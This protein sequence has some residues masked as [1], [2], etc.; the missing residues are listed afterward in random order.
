MIQK[1]IMLRINEVATAHK[2]LVIVFLQSVQLIFKSC[3][4]TLLL[5]FLF[6][7]NRLFLYVINGDRKYF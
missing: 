5:F 1:S 6:D 4:R 3:L 2:Y 7:I